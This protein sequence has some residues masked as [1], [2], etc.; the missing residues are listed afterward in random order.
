M[1]SFLLLLPGLCC[2]CF[3]PPKARQSMVPSRRAAYLQLF[4]RRQLSVS[5]SPLFVREVV[6]CQRCVVHVF[7]TFFSFF[8]PFC[9]QIAVLPGRLGGGDSKGGS[10][11]RVHFYVSIAR[12]L[13]IAA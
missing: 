5:F 6:L 9:S 2:V 13:K 4:R 10:W 1:L 12:D 8:F 3:R 11:R 7:V